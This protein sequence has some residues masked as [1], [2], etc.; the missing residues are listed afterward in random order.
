MISPPEIFLLTPL[1]SLLSFHLLLLVLWSFFV[2]SA[3]KG[4]SSHW[5]P[6]KRER[7]AEAKEQCKPQTASVADI[8]SPRRNSAHE[9]HEEGK[10]AVRNIALSRWAAKVRPRNAVSKPRNVTPS[11][12][13][14]LPEQQAQCKAKLRKWNSSACLRS[15]RRSHS[16]VQTFVIK[17]KLWV[18]WKK[19]SNKATTSQCVCEK[20]ASFQ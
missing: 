10:A 20:L 13:G 14:H 17:E 18:G 3:S 5:S 15:S 2:S 11:V 7:R 6:K 9:V 1:A 16:F 4:F 19:F 12:S 8:N